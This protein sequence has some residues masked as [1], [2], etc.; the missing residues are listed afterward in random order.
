MV[1]ITGRLGAIVGGIALIVVGAITIL[2]VVLP[3][4]KQQ[5]WGA[6]LR[7]VFKEVSEQKED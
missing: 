4:K 6:M 1:N 3:F 2:F 5:E 7:K